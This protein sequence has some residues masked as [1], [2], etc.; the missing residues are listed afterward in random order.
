MRVACARSVQ[1]RDRRAD[2][3]GRRPR[4]L[5]GCLRADARRPGA[6]RPARGGDYARDAFGLFDE[7]AAACDAGALFRRRDRR[8]TCRDLLGRTGRR[9]D[10]PLLQYLFDLHAARLRQRD[11]RRGDPAAARRPLSGSGRPGGRGWCDAPRG[12]RSGLFRLHSQPDGGLSARRARTAQPALYGLAER[13][14][15]RRALSARQGR[16]GGMARRGLRAV[17]DRPR[18]PAR[19][20]AT[21][22]PC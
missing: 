3:L 10:R 16:G 6:A 11:P 9:G 8:R 13:C 20:R 12:V 18:P 1:S 17:A 19:R 7:P 21:T 5:S 4:P 2:R 15:L 14:A 22:W